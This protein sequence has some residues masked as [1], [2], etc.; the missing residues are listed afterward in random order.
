MYRT[1]THAK[2][3][4]QTQIEAKLIVCKSCKRAWFMTHRRLKCQECRRPKK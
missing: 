1:P 4:D 3:Y 2:T